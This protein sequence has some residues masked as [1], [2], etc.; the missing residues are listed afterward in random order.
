MEPECGERGSAGGRS[1]QLDRRLWL[2]RG[3]GDPKHCIR[4][5]W[6]IVWSATVARLLALWN[7]GM[8]DPAL[9]G[10]KPPSWEV[11]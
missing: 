8:R 6:M 7:P 11:I 10:A 2:I 1:E 4:C 5:G 3:H 9:G